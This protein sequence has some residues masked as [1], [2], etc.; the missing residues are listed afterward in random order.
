VNPANAGGQAAGGT[1]KMFVEDYAT[2]EFYEADAGDG[3]R[4]GARRRRRGRGGRYYDAGDGPEEAAGG[5][6]EMV[7]AKDLA[8]SVFRGSLLLATALQGLLAGL[9]LVFVAGIAVNARDAGDG[10][11]DGWLVPFGGSLDVLNGTVHL[12]LC[13]AAGH[14]WHL[15]SVERRSSR[16]GSA[17]RKQRLWIVLVLYA[18]AFAANVGMAPLEVKLTSAAR[19]HE[20]LDFRTGTESYQQWGQGESPLGSR[21]SAVTAG[22]VSP[23]FKGDLTMWLLGNAVRGGCSIVAWVVFSLYAVSRMA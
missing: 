17:Q 4:G 14:S 13:L 21:D 6:Q 9:L 16:P 10:T 2:G 1:A 11:L 22:T 7:P 15:L 12:L 18:V 23:D 19:S 5:E 3:P 20:L 8:R